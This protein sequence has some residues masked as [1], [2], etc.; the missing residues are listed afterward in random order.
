[1]MADETNP[2]SDIAKCDE[3]GQVSSF[4]ALEYEPPKV[5]N[6]YEVPAGS[7]FQIS[8]GLS[9]ALSLYYPPMG[10]QWL[11]L[12]IIPFVV[13]WVGFV[14]FWTIMSLKVNYF[15]PIVSLPFWYVG[16]SMLKG[17]YLNIRGWER[18]ELDRQYIRHIT[19]HGT[20]SK[21]R[22]IALSDVV[23]IALRY[24]KK[25]DSSPSEGFKSMKLDTKKQRTIDQQ[26]AIVLLEEEIFFFESAS[27]PEQDWIIELLKDLRMKMG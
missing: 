12:F 22:Q 18:V 23:D 21:T 16:I 15:L 4:A 9:K 14:A 19:G 8:Q 3:C 11:H 6:L 26:P 24:K 10:F 7:R 2:V 25:A 1:M 5:K 13:F 20:N 27:D 17:V